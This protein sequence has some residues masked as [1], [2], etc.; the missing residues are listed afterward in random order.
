MTNIDSAICRFETRLEALLN[1]LN[2]IEKRIFLVAAKRSFDEIYE[3]Y[4]AD[5]MAKPIGV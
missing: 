5:V 1:E 2:E 3:Q 4:N